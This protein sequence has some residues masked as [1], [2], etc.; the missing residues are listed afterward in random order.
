MKICFFALFAD[1]EMDDYDQPIDETDPNSG[2]FVRYQ[3]T[4]Q[5]LHLKHVGA[6]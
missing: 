2:R 5:F 3:F 6:T 1:E 4:P